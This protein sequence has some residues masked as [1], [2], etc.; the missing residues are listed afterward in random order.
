MQK[1]TGRE[2]ARVVP[3]VKDCKVPEKT[4]SERAKGGEAWL[5]QGPLRITGGSF[6][7]LLILRKMGAGEKGDWGWE[8]IDATDRTP[9]AV[10]FQTKLLLWDLEKE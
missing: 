5:D 2:G 3:G 4:S 10:C 7:L 8:R 1:A 6:A 9:S